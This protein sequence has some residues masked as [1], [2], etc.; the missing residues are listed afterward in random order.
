MLALAPSIQSGALLGDV[1]K[2]VLCNLASFN[3]G[4]LH[5]HGEYWQTLTTSL[6]N[7]FPF[8]VL[9][10]IGHEVSILDFSSL[11]KVFSR[12][13]L[14]T[15]SDLLTTFFPIM[16]HARILFCLFSRCCMIACDQVT[17]HNLV[18]WALSTL[19]ILCLISRLNPPSPD[20]AMVL[21]T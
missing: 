12:V 2:V 13:N 20:Y 1:S 11:T 5:E 21:D 19:P 10:L 4:F 6:G 17:S 3:A 8:E 14:T 7:P 15:L 18:R 16:L 9:Q